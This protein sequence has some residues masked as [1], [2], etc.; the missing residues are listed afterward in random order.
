MEDGE[1]GWR[2]FGR[3]GHGQ[4]LMVDGQWGQPDLSAINHQP[5]T[6]NH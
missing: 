3:P 2:V 1:G 5:S 6:I 4:W